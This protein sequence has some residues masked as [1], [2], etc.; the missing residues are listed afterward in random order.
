[1]A[2]VQ[3]LYIATADGLAQLANPGTS[4]RWRVVDQTLPGQNVVAVSASR[5]DSLVAIAGTSKAI[6]ATVDGGV[7]W[8]SAYNAEI[9]A[10]ASDNDGTLYAGTANSLILASTDA[11][12]WN[13][14]HTGLGPVR[15]LRL[16]SDGRIAA[17]Y[18]NGQVEA[19]LADGTWKGQDVCVP[20][21]AEIVSSAA[22]PNELYITN[23][24][25]LVTHWGIRPVMQVPTGAIVLLA[26]KPEVILLGTQSGIQRSEDAGG[27]L[28]T[29]EG[30]PRAV[31]VLVNPPRYEDWAYAGT[32]SGELWLSKDRGRTWTQLREGMAPIRDLSFARVQ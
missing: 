13:E 11:I 5:T 9:T 10:T 18:T 16:L 25:G 22:E 19:L 30:G 27:N 4:D 2:Q 20:R 14:I 1:M 23:A 3:I 24:K 7:S 29:V 17:V 26:G 15:H 32:A 12:I 21:I 31:H 6:H 28:T 8:Q